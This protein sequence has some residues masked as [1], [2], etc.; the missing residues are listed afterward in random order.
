LWG[1]NFTKYVSGH[2]AASGGASRGRRGYERGRDACGHTPRRTA[3]PTS[4]R[5]RDARRP[6]VRASRHAARFEGTRDLS[7]IR[8]AIRSSVRRSPAPDVPDRR[9]RRGCRAPGGPGRRVAVGH[10]AAT[11]RRCPPGPHGPWRGPPRPSRSGDGAG[12]TDG[13]PGRPRRR[14][15]RRT[16]RCLPTSGDGGP[17]APTGRAGWRFEPQPLRTDRPTDDEDP[18]CTSR[19]HRKG[20]APVDRP[21][22][23]LEDRLLSVGPSVSPA[24]RGRWG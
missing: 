21:S 20:E 2:G 5:T 7:P 17:P 6:T 13:T 18:G 15:V 1:I 16:H 8:G 4:A 14:R 3:S 22:A 12:A 11:R 23:L 19:P 10:P 9:R 24:T